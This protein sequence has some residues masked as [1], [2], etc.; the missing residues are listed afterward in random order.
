MHRTMFCAV[1][2]FMCSCLGY[3]K[4]PPSDTDSASLVV[5]GGTYITNGAGSFRTQSS[6]GHTRSHTNAPQHNSVTRE[7]IVTSDPC[8]S[9]ASS[10]ISDA[11]ECV[12]G[13]LGTEGDITGHGSARVDG[14]ISVGSDVV[15]DPGANIVLQGG[16]VVFPVP[17][18]VALSEFTAITDTPA[19]G[20]ARFVQGRW[21]LFSTAAFVY[22][23]IPYNPGRVLDGFSWF[24][25]K[26]NSS[27]SLVA[28]IIESDIATGAQGEI[29][30]SFASVGSGLVGDRV[31]SSTGEHYTMSPIK[32]YA[33][34]AWAQN[35]A[36]GL[37]NFGAAT[38][39]LR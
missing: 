25:T 39:I 36:N 2:I 5:Q 31:V 35:V 7:A 8:S 9:A 6:G 4:V 28:D 38:I 23:P 37:D 12:F 21:L 33:I 24:T 14:G 29:P 20:G 10:G 26:N 11:G 1:S 19:T 32:T 13:P 15:L 18:T 22:Y 17:Q 30:G 34:R 27:S 3:E 16:R